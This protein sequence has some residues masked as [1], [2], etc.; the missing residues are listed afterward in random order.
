MS[1]PKPTPK[2]IDKFK[3][4]IKKKSFKKTERRMAFKEGGAVERF[5]QR[6]PDYNPED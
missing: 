5:L 4:P 6:H 1:L 2:K 3:K